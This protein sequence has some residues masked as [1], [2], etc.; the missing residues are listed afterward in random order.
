MLL[1]VN[2]ML[3]HFSLGY[4]LRIAWNR[5]KKSGGVGMWDISASPR[6]NI[7]PTERYEAKILTAIETQASHVSI[8]K[9]LAV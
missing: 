9:Y 8:A 1:I 2:S 7:V 4:K 5:T 3:F 6:Q